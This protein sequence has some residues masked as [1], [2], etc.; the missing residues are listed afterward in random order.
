MEVETQ[1]ISSQASDSESPGFRSEL[2]RAWTV[3]QRIGR[4][5]LGKPLGR[6]GMGVVYVA[7]D[8]LLG[9]VVALKV[10]REDR[11]GSVALSRVLREAQSLAR[12]SHPNVVQV[13]DISTYNGQIFIAME[14]ISGGTL[15]EW[16]GGDEH[17]FDAI[18]DVFIQA[19]KGLAAAHE[20][21]IIHR[22]FKPDNV[23]V[24]VDGRA[25]VA[26]FGLAAGHIAIDAIDDRG[27]TARDSEYEERL[28]R[29]GTILGTPR[30]MSPEHREGAV[31]DARADQFSFCVALYEAL[32]KTHPF[33]D[34]GVAA[35]PPKEGPLWVWPLL[36]RGLSLVPDQRFEDLDQLLVKLGQN[37]V[38]LRW[39][40]LRLVGLL[41]LSAALAAGLIFV[42]LTLTKRW[43]EA[44]LEADASRAY[45]SAQRRIE[46]AHS[47]GEPA[48]AER[49]FRSIVEDPT[50]DETQVLA[51][52]WLAQ[53]R[54]Q[55][56]AG[57]LEAGRV[58]AAN[59]YT[60]G[61][62]PQQ[63]Q[64]ALLT[65]AQVFERDFDWAGLSQLINL[66]A[67]EGQMAAEDEEY[68]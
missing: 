57:N 23:L 5:Q 6:G 68:Q 36:K 19:G 37:P 54:R 43:H 49:I 62:T 25:R 15:R 4:Y 32:Y 45:A 10:L 3:G 2:T 56:A 67:R 28:T 12:L 27:S 42:G 8:E 1:T 55:T 40:R 58:A 53:A 9:R 21:G 44:A 29:A 22:D 24:G 33:S 13:Y 66:L 47:R 48:E 11:T 16:L 26:D 41:L 65:L 64:D 39:Q 60:K 30:Y 61:Q 35:S 50:Y 51:Q 52:A 63:R 34:V 20:V 7:D 59:A 46:Q 18:L 17:R 38:H 31:L 14:F